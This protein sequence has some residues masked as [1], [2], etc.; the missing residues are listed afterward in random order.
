MTA[1]ALHTATLLP[2]GSVLV[3]GGI[4]A[5]GNALA[6]AELV[7]ASGST[8]AP[9]LA[10]AR[11]GHTATRLNNGKVLVAGGQSSAQATTVFT[12]SELY[13]PVAGSFAPGPTLTTGRSEAIAVEFGTNGNM[14]VLIAGGSNG[15]TPVA[16]AEIYDEATNTT[17]AVS[18]SMV[19]AHAGGMA[20]LMD[21][22]TVLIVGGIGLTGP[23]GAEVFNPATNTFSAVSM[24]TKRSGAAFASIGN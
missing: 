13:D 1:R 15:T 7:T 12:S 19:E 9:H 20:A 17:T 18:G 23:A 6:S 14:S 22:G 2:S 11:V 5:T 16:S 4:D 3:V 24:S 10:T 8:T 21:D